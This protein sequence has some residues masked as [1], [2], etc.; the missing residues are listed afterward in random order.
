M[1]RFFIKRENIRK[2]GITLEGED[3]KHISRVLRLQP[4]D[5]LVLC[6]GE[7]TDYITAIESID[8]YSVKTMIINK[9]TSKGESGIDV[10]LYQGIPKSTKM[11]LIIQ[12]CTEM[13]IRRIVPV[14]TARTVVRLESEKDEKKKVER[15]TKIAEEAAKQSGRG[16]IPTVDMPVSLQEAFEDAAELDA[17]IV[18]YEQEESISVKEAL[19]KDK[20][21]SIGFFIG[22]E[23]GFEASE[24]LAAKKM[25]ALPVTLGSR[26][27]RT[28]TAGVV[29]LACIM[30]EYDQLK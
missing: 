17:V 25:G 1:H 30:Y 16:V 2:G 13:G 24:M 9:E 8:K 5:K 28:E 10:I 14:Y 27:L 4:G 18:P 6:D 19:S 26:I 29:V 20:V 23:G 22:P 7:G 11:D 12:K 21:G 15:W 3:V